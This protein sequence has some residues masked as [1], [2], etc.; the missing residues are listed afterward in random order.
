MDQLTLKSSGPICDKLRKN[1]SI[2]SSTLR[3]MSFSSEYDGAEEDEDRCE[4]LLLV[5]MRV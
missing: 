2:A 5:A 1:D 4:G 3:S